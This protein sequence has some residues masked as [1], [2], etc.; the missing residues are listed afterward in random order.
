ME[1]LL[2]AIHNT[3]CELKSQTLTRPNIDQ[4]Y[5]ISAN[6]PLTL[7]YKN[8]Y[9]VYMWSANA[10]TLTIEDL[11]NV[12]VSASAWVDISFAPSTKV[13]ASGQNTLT[14]V[15]I[16]CTDLEMPPPTS[17]NSVLGAV[18]ANAGTNLNTSAL[19]L[20]SGGHLATID[21]STAASKTDLDSI[22]T[23]T[24]SLA[25]HSDATTI[26]TT[27][28]TLATQSTLSAAKTDL[29]TIVTNTNKI[30]ASPAQEGGNLATIAGAITASKMQD[31]IAQFGGNAVVTGTGA[32]G[33]GIPRVTVSNDSQVQGVVGSSGGSIPYHNLSAN[34]TNFTNL[35]GVA[36]QMYGYVLSNTSGS[37]IFVKFYDKA[38]APGTGDT[39]KRTIQVPANSTIIQTIPLGLKFTVGFGWAATGAIADNDNTA[40]AANCGIDFDLNS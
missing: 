12:S 25:T 2:R 15:L 32:S 38:T 8:R 37:A 18:T 19:A 3:L 40:I 7:D 11:G 4:I 31:N 28:G 36:C 39:P 9:R 20:E 29:D 5:Q 16:R 34:T 1:E 26:N 27:L 14:P 23:N 21:T 30:P 10:L 13:F 22:V 24:T 35:K 6:N 33:N 17:S